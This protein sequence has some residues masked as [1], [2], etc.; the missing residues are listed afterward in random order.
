MP[1]A[2]LIPIAAQIGA[3]MIKKL[4]E[5]KIGAENA[6]LAEE[7]VKQIASRA[8][9][10][11]EDLGRMVEEDAATIEE[12]I[13]DTERSPELARLYAAGL[14]GQFELLKAEGSDSFWMRAWRPGWMWLLGFLWLWS[15]VIAHVVNA[16]FKI[17]LPPPDLWVLFQLTALFA[18]FYMGGHTFKDFVATRWGTK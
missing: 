4:L 12:A 18:A 11:P 15:I 17:A 5:K 2:A 14:E 16:V 3:P 8:A 7:V 1:A 13:M 10:L 6:D 9:V